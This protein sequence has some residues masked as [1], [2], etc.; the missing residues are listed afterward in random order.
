VKLGFWKIAMRPGKPLMFGRRGHQRV[1]G[2]PG[3]PV[4]SM[5]C[6]RLFIKPLIAALTGDNQPDEPAKTVL[7]AAMKAN[8]QRQDY[9]RATLDRNGKGQLVATAFPKQD[10]SM[11]RV[12][13]EADCLIIR[14]PHAPAAKAGELADVLL[15][16]F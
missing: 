4:S 3:N 14:P 16:D 13:R 2:L 12:F 5:V 9:V 10:S 1:I 7:G 6:T 11:Q 15:L 8:D